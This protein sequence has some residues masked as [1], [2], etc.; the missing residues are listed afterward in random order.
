MEEPNALLLVKNHG[1]VVVSVG[2]RRAPGHR[3]PT[4]IHD[5]WDALKWVG[6]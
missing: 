6:D 1:A 3:F 2:Y 4:A 5:S